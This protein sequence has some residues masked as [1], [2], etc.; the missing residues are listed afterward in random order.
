MRK[1]LTV[2]RMATYILRI[3]QFG[4]IA[5]FE[6][7]F[8]SEGK[9]FA[10]LLPNF[11]RALVVQVPEGKLDWF[12]LITSRFFKSLRYLE[13]ICP[14]PVANKFFPR[15]IVEE[16]LHEG[17]SVFLVCNERYFDVRVEI[18][19]KLDYPTRTLQFGLIRVL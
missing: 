16:R 11:V 13:H 12:G 7:K 19:Y 2:K 6:T 17:T 4:I 18:R 5:P 14:C 3:Y 10:N 8:I 9:V 15:F 1:A